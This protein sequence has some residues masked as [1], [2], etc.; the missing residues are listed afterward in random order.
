[1]RLRQVLTNLA[2]NAVKFTSTGGVCVSVEPRRGATL[3]GSRSLTPAR[4]CRPIGARRSSRI[5]NKA[6]ARN[7]RRFEGAGSRPRHFPPAR[8]ADGRLADAYEDNPGG[9]SIFA[10]TVRLPESEAA[11]SAGAAD[12]VP[13]ALEGRRALIIANSPFEAP[14]IAARLAEAGASVTRAEGLE[15]GLAALAEPSRPDLVIVDC[16][17][18]PEATNRLAQAARAAGAPQSLVLFSPFERRAFGQ[19]SLQGFDGWLVK[20]VRARS[21]FERLAAEF[22]E[23][24]R[25][26]APPSQP[27]RVELAP[28]ASRRGQRHQRAHRAKGPASSRFRSDPGEGRRRGGA[29]CRANGAWRVVAVR[30]DPDGPQ[31]AGGRRRRGDTAAPLA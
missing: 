4:A 8:R 10:F 1:M 20:P 15:S 21:L 22:P 29:A 30:R 2:G 9:G 17:L 7:A 23:R 28:R 19:T 24:P 5:S 12:P 16:A 13:V 31:D 18:G 25:L 6:T 14:A 27:Q 26:A 3:C 11:A